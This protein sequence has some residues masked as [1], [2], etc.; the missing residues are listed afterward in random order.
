MGARS[1]DDVPTRP[2]QKIDSKKSMFTIFF[3]DEKL[4]FLD[5]LPEGKNMDS[6]YFYNTVLERVK[7]GALAGTRK[8]TLR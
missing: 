4:A 6:H 1:H 5:S 2:P 8:V 7:A 3:S